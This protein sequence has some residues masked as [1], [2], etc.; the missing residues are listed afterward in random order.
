VPRVRV[1]L[2]GFIPTAVVRSTDPQKK[3]ENKSLSVKRQQNG[4]RNRNRDR[5][6]IPRFEDSDYD[7]DYDYDNDNDNDNEKYKRP[8]SLLDGVSGPDQL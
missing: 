1:S 3:S 6:Q 8:H 4:C 2:C 7:Y 5:V